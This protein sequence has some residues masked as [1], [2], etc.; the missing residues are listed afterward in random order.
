MSPPQGFATTLN[1][2]ALRIF[3]G[4]AKQ[5]RAFAEI[6]TLDAGVDIAVLFALRVQLAFEIQFLCVRL[7]L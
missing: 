2:K 1:F 7:Q 3:I 6:A 5:K 4:H